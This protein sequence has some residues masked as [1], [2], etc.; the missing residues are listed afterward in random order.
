MP[1]APAGL[2][3]LSRRYQD[4]AANEARGV[5]PT[6]E[7]LALAVA[8]SH[9]LLSFIA[10]LSADRRQPN[11][12]LAAVRHLSGVPRDG[13]QLT[14]IVRLDHA[15]LRA[16]MLTRTTQT[17][18]PARC[19]VL[20]P[21]LARLPQPLALLE[22]GASAGLCL[23]PDR[24]GYA[25][26][27]LRLEPTCRDAVPH[28]VFGCETSGP[29][30][31]PTAMPTIVWRLG[32]DLNPLDVREPADVGWLE[33]LVW[34][35]QPVRAEGLR[36]AITIAQRTPPTVV[37]G[38][39]LNDLESLMAR[40]PAA[41][42]LVVFH[43]A[44]L[45]YVAAQADRDRFA[46]TVRASRAVWISNEAPNVFPAIAGAA[47]PPPR[48]RF[49]LAIDGQPVAWTGPHGQSIDWFAHSTTARS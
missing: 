20:L 44:V 13:D 30:P 49:L 15:R 37:K 38:D 47:P 3:R 36:A 14:E 45:G 32:L 5:S 40:A 23:Q 9:E 42:T 31:V 24:Y 22:V 18:E 29:V 27:G 12:F 1:S 43:T 39:L 19:A 7:R 46:D 21:L 41:A 10:S 4:F 28:P 16:E 48:G 8:G 2:E 17:N 33:S 25:Y 11:L 26:G 35:D 34:P 6:Y